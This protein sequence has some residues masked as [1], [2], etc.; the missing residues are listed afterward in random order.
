ME[1]GFEE[2]LVANGQELCLWRVA[3]QGK[4]AGDAP[5]LLAKTLLQF[6]PHSVALSPDGK[7]AVAGNQLTLTLA[8]F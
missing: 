4:T 7:L 6:Q 8:L 3:S 5:T 2:V 1:E